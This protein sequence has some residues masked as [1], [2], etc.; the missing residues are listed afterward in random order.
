MENWDHD[1]L[2]DLPSIDLSPIREMG[3]LTQTERDRLVMPSLRL[4]LHRRRMMPVAI[5]AGGIAAFAG[6]I[7]MCAVLMSADCGSV[8][9]PS[10]G[11]RISMTEALEAAFS[12][13]VVPVATASSAKADLVEDQVIV[14]PPSKVSIRVAKRKI[15][16]R[17]I[18][19][20]GSRIIRRS[21]TK[22]M[23][24]PPERTSLTISELIRKASPSMPSTLSK[25]KIVAAMKRAA[26]AV[27]RCY[28]RFRVPGTADV[29]FR[30][31]GS[32][33]VEDLKVEGMFSGT[34]T[35]QCVESA[36]RKVRFPEFLAYSMAVRWPFMLK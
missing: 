6:M 5:I 20:R 16:K 21:R 24:R 23:R 9:S 19:K 25:G 11:S 17:R 15:A 28:K 10:S 7:V 13:A 3:P 30:I 33:R 22:A 8:D 26:P 35:G 12:P 31:M 4:Q 27:G 18:V 29:R 34:P 32:G 2:V 36:V 14:P 1:T